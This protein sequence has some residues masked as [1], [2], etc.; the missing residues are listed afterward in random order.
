M[1]LNVV[2]IQVELCSKIKIIKFMNH[3]QHHTSDEVDESQYIY[4]E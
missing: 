4:L 3:D 2:H 1:K